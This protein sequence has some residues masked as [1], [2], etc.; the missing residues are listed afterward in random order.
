[1][2]KK[3]SKVLF[4]VSL[5]VLT[6]GAGI[7]SLVSPKSASAEGSN[8]LSI[9]IEGKNYVLEGTTYGT[10]TFYRID[11]AEDLS[12]VSF[13]V[14]V[15]KDKN[16]AGY[17]YELA[18]DIN[19]SSRLWTA[20]GTYDN[21]FTGKFS[22]NG[23]TINGL[24]SAKDSAEAEVFF[25]G[26]SV[27]EP[28]HNTYYHDTT[29]D[30]Y[31]LYQNSGDYIRGYVLQETTPASST[32]VTAKNYYYYG[33]FGRLEKAEVSDVVMGKSCYVYRNNILDTTVDVEAYSGV[34]AAYAKDTTFYN[35][36]DAMA[37]AETVY[38]KEY[39]YFKT[40]DTS[41]LVS[42]KKYY[43]YDEG[44]GT[45]SLVESPELAN[46]GLYYEKVF[47]VN[48]GI[49]NY[50]YSYNIETL[51][52]YNSENMTEANK[53]VSINVETTKT[54]SFRAVDKAYYYDYNA[55]NGTLWLNLKER[56]IVNSVV[57]TTDTETGEVTTINS[58]EVAG[59][60]YYIFG[61]DVEIRLSTTNE[62]PAGDAT[63]VVNQETEEITLDGETY[64][65]A[66][67][68]GILKILAYSEVCSIGYVDQESSFYKGNYYRLN[69][70]DY[71]GIGSIDDGAEHDGVLNMLGAT[72]YY[73]YNV[74][75]ATGINRLVIYSGDY[76]VA[77][78]IGNDAGVGSISVNGVDYLF[79]YDATYKDLDIS[80]ISSYLTN[81]PYT[82][83]ET[84]GAIK[85]E[86]LVV[87]TIFSFSTAINGVET[88][89]Y[90]YEKGTTNYITSFRMIYDEKVGLSSLDYSSNFVST[91]KDLPRS[92]ERAENGQYYIVSD[93]P[94][95]KFVEWTVPRKSDGAE[96]IVYVDKNESDPSKAFI[97][98]IPTTDTEA[99][100]GKTYYRAMGVGV[101]EKVTDGSFD[102]GYHEMLSFE[103][104]IENIIANNYLVN[105][106]WEAKSYTVNVD[107]AGTVTTKTVG[108]GT[109]WDSFVSSLVNAGHDLTGVY[110]YENGLI[111]GSKS[112][113]LV[114]TYSLNYF[115]DNYGNLSTFSYLKTSDSELV[116]GKEYFTCM[117]DGDGF[118]RFTLVETPNVAN[119]TSYY[120][121]A[122]N[123]AIYGN[124]LSNGATGTSV[125]MVEW[126]DANAYLYTTWQRQ[127]VNGKITFTN[128]GDEYIKTSDETLVTGKTYYTYDA[129]SGYS[130]VT[131]P[132]EIDLDLYY[133]KTTKFLINKFA[134]NSGYETNGFK[135]IAMAPSIEGNNTQFFVKLDTEEEN[136][137]FGIK[138][139]AN[140]GY[141][142][143]YIAPESTGVLDI[144]TIDYFMYDAV[145]K[146]LTH[147]YYDS[148]NAVLTSE[149][150]TAKAVFG[151]FVS[152]QTFLEIKDGGEVTHGT[153]YEAFDAT[154]YY[155]DIYYGSMTPNANGLA[156][157]YMADGLAAD[158][159]TVI[160]TAKTIIHK[161]GNEYTYTQN[162][163]TSNAYNLYI[164]F[165]RE[166]FEVN[167]KV[168]QDTGLEGYIETITIVED[169]ETLESITNVREDSS[170]TM[171]VKYDSIYDILVQPADTY[172]I[173]TFEAV[174]MNTPTNETSASGLRI[175]GT[176]SDLKYTGE[177]PT[178]IFE[179]KQSTFDVYSSYNYGI[180]NAE[181]Y[182][183]ALYQN[184]ATDPVLYIQPVNSS[185]TTQETTV[186]K[187]NREDVEITNYGQ[188]AKII[189][190][191]NAYYDV[192]YINVN[193]FSIA[194]DANG[195]FLEKVNATNVN[196]VTYTATS[197]WATVNYKGTNYL[198][199]NDGTQLVADGEGWKL[200]N[201]NLYSTTPETTTVD[202][203]QVIPAGLIGNGDIVELEPILKKQ[204]YT[205]AVDK[206][207]EF[208]DSVFATLRDVNGNEGDGSAFQHYEIYSSV[209]SYSF[210]DSVVLTA[211][212]NAQSIAF[213]SHRFIGWYA[214]IGETINAIMLNGVVD[215]RFNPNN[216]TAQKLGTFDKATNTLTFDKAAPAN[217]EIYAIFAPNSINV[218]TTPLYGSFDSVIKNYDGKAGNKLYSFGNVINAS[219]TMLSL[220]YG[221]TSYA[222][223][224]KRTI[225]YTILPTAGFSLKGWAVVDDYAVWAANGGKTTLD[226]SIDLLDYVTIVYEYENPITNS[227]DIALHYAE[228]LNNET[229]NN[230][231]LFTKLFALEQNYTKGGF[232]LIPVLQ[233]KTVTVT[234]THDEV[235]SKVDNN[236]ED[237]TGLIYYVG[238]DGLDVSAYAERF[239]YQGYTA[240]G[241]SCPDISYTTYSN[242]INFAG[243]PLNY[244][245]TYTVERT[246]APNDYN[247]YLEVG[248]GESI[249]SD[250][251]TVKT[252]ATGKYIA[253]KYAGTFNLPTVGKTGYTFQGWKVKG[254]ETVF[255]DEGKYY[256]AGNTT[257]VPYFTA[258]T[259]KVK[260]LANYG[261]YG[262]DTTEKTVNVVYD[263]AII[264]NAP[265]PTRDGYTFKE[266]ALKND[267]D[268]LTLSS[269]T[270]LSVALSDVDLDEEIVL[271]VY[272]RWTRVADYYTVIPGDA[273]QTYE[274]T[275]SP[276]NFELF[277]DIKAG[278]TSIFD[279][280]WGKVPAT[281]MAV[282]AG[283]SVTLPNGDEIA[284]SLN[285]WNTWDYLEGKTLSLTNVNESGTN[286]IDYLEVYDM[287]EVILSGEYLTT[288]EN[289]LKLIDNKEYTF[290]ITPRTVAKELATSYVGEFDG[291]STLLGETFKN[292]LA[293]GV[294]IDKV[295]VN[296]YAVGH[297]DTQG[298]FT[299]KVD[300]TADGQTYNTIRFY[301]TFADGYTYRPEY[302]NY[303]NVGVEGGKYYFD[304][305][306][307][308]T[309]NKKTIELTP[310]AAKIAYTGSAQTVIFKSSYNINSQEINF[311]ANGTLTAGNYG[312]ANSN[313]TIAVSATTMT[314]SG[315]GF[316]NT[317][318]LGSLVLTSNYNYVLTGS[319]EILGNVKTYGFSGVLVTR[320]NNTTALS[321]PAAIE[322]NIVVNSVEFTAG[323]SNVTID[324]TAETNPTGY[325]IVKMGDITYIYSSNRETLYYQIRNDVNEVAIYS[326]YDVNAVTVGTSVYETN[327]HIFGSYVYDNAAGSGSE[328]D[329]IKTVLQST[330]DKSRYT[331][332][333]TGTEYYVIYTDLQTVQFAGL[334]DAGNE[335]VF[336]Y[337]K[338]GESL[339]YT[340]VGN[341]IKT[342]Y[343]FAGW[344]DA[345]TEP[346]T[347]S[348]DNDEI[349]TT[350]VTQPQNYFVINSTWN[351]QAPTVETSENIT[352]TRE[353]HVD[354]TTQGFEVS[355]SEIVG[356]I[357]NYN[358]NLTYNATIYAPDNSE[359]VSASIQSGDASF[360][361][362]VMLSTTDAGVY[363]LKISVTDADGKTSETTVN[364][365]LVVNRIAVELSTTETYTTKTGYFADATK[366]ALGDDYKFEF[367]YSHGKS[368]ED[369]IYVTLN[370]NGMVDKFSLNS[371][372][373]MD[374][375]EE[376]QGEL[377]FSYTIKKTIDTDGSAIDRAVSTIGEVGTY[378]VTINIETTYYSAEKQLYFDVVI[379]PAELTFTDASL[380]SLLGTTA[381]ETAFEKTYGDD[382]SVLTQTFYVGANNIVYATAEA[383]GVGN[384]AIEVIF[385]GEGDKMAFDSTTSR[386][387][388]VGNYA[389]TK[390]RTTNGNFTISVSSTTG[391]VPY[392][393]VVSNNNDELMFTVDNTTAPSFTYGDT[394]ITQVKLAWNTTAGKWELQGFDENDVKK[395]TWNLSNIVAGATSYISNNTTFTNDKY[396]FGINTE[397]YPDGL[398]LAGVYA[399]DALS[400]SSLEGALLTKVSFTTGNILTIAQKTLTITSMAREELIIK[401][402]TFNSDANTE[403]TFSVEGL[404]YGDTVTLS[405]TIAG[406]NGW[407][408]GTQTVTDLT[409]GG[410][411]ATNYKLANTTYAS[412]TIGK[413][414]ADVVV[415]IAN[416]SYG[417][418]DINEIKTLTSIKTGT[419]SLIDLASVNIEGVE[420]LDTDEV[421][422]TE[423]STGGYVKA[424]T[425]KVRL[426]L[427]SS[428]FTKAAGEFVV[429]FVVEKAT[430]TVAPSETIEK[431][432]DGNDNVLQSF[433]F[434]SKSGDVVV[435]TGKYA[436]VAEANGI[437]I[438]LTKTGA[439]AVNYE[440]APETAITGNILP[441]DGIGLT[442]DNSK[443]T[444][445]EDGQKPYYVDA[446]KPTADA[447]GNFQITAA[448]S[449]DTTGADIVAAL[450]NPVRTG[451]RFDGFFTDEDL[452]VALSAD[453][454][455][456]LINAHISGEN[457][458]SNF[459]VYAKWTIVA[460][461]IA[462]TAEGN[463]DLE[464]EKTTY[465]YYDDVAFTVTA[466]RGYTLT[467]VAAN[468]TGKTT[469]VDLANSGDTYS[470]KM[471]AYG[472]T[473]TRTTSPNK[474]DIAY[475][476]DGGSFEAPQ[477]QEFTFGIGATIV[478]PIKK[479]HKFVGW[480]VN[481]TGSAVQTTG[482][483]VIGATTYAD[484]ISLTAKWEA[485]T[486]RIY[487][488]VDETVET[489]NTTGL[490]LDN[491]SSNAETFK[492]YY[493]EIV[494]GTQISLPESSKPGYGF[495][496]WVYG[497][498]DTVLAAGSNYEID[499]NVIVKAVYEAGTFETT[500]TA[501]HATITVYREIKSQENIVSPTGNKYSMTGGVK[502]IINVKADT[503]YKVGYA[504]YEADS[505]ID[506]EYYA[507]ENKEINFVAEALSHTIAINVNQQHKSLIEFVVT[508]DGQVVAPQSVEAGYKFEAQTD[509]VVT[510]KVTENA[511]Y[512]L[513]EPVVS[514]LE[515]TPNADGDVFT[516][517]GYTT[518]ASITFSLTAL[519]YDITINKDADGKISQ[520]DF[521]EGA[522]STAQH[523]TYWTAN[524]TTDA[525]TLQF[526]PTVD[527]GYVFRGVAYN[528]T[529]VNINDR[530]ENIGGTTLTIAID[531]SGKVSITGYTGAATVDLL[532]AEDSYT[533]KLSIIALDGEKK[534]TSV[535]SEIKVNSEAYDASNN[536]HLYNESITI[537]ANVTTS[538]YKFVGWFTKVTDETDGTVSYDNINLMY[539]QDTNTFT[540][541]NSNIEYIAVFE[542]TYLDINFSVLTNDDVANNKGGKVEDIA[543]ET[544][545]TDRPLYKTN[546]TYKAVASKGYKFV[547][548]YI[549]D[550]EDNEVDATTLA[551][552]TITTTE[553]DADD[554]I[555]ESTLAFE[556][557]DS[558]KVYAKF[559]AK[560]LE[561][562]VSKGLLV[563]GTLTYPDSI[564]YGQVEWGTYTVDGGFV[565]DP[566][567]SSDTI[568]T[569]TDGVVY[570]K[571][572]A[573]DG[574]LIDGIV[575]T[576]KGSFAIT[577]IA[578]Q[579]GYKIYELAGMNADDESHSFVARFYSTE[580]ILTINYMTASGRV[581]EGGH[582]VVTAGEG[583]S[584]SA[585]RSSKVT[586]TAITGSTIEI[587]AFTRLGYHF[588]KDPDT[589][590]INYSYLDAS[591]FRGTLE[592]P[593]TI[594]V[595][596]QD[597]S[598]GY[599]EAVSFTISGFVG[600]NINLSLIVNVDRY[601]VELYAVDEDL[602]VITSKPVATIENVSG[603][604]MITPDYNAQDKIS[605][606]IKIPGYSL[607]GFYTY[608]N[609]S[610]I[611]YINARGEGVVTLNDNGY[612]WNGSS[613]QK[614]P[615]YR[616][617]INGNGTFSLFA[618]YTIDKTAIS[619]SASPFDL[620]EIAPTVSTKVVI[621]NLNNANSWTVET[622]E[623]YA[624]VLYGATVNATAPKFA[625]H[626]FAF[627]QIE[628][629]D[630]NGTTSIRYNTSETIVDL[631]DAKSGKGHAYSSM[632]L[633]AVYYVHAEVSATSG[634]SATITGYTYNVASNGQTA[635]RIEKIV[636][637]Q[638]DFSSL[639]PIVYK[640]TP[641]Y[642]YTFE[643]WA[644]EEGQIVYTSEEVTINPEDA[645]P[646]FLQAVFTGD[647]KTLAITSDSS[648]IGS[649]E[650]VYRLDEE[651]MEVEI[652]DLSNI[653]VR[654]GDV[655]YIDVKVQSVSYEA[656]WSGGNVDADIYST[657][658]ARRY[659]YTVAA[660]DEVE[661]NI[662]RLN[663]SYESRRFDITVKYDLNDKVSTDEL[664]LA[665]SIVYKKVER[666]SGYTINTIYG[667]AVGVNINVKKNYKVASIVIDGIE[668][669]DIKKYAN[670]GT[671]TIQTTD[672]I[673]EVS[674]SVVVEIT[675]ERV[676]W[677]D[678][679]DTT[680]TLSGKGTDEN[681]YKIASEEDLA[682]LAYMV[683]VKKDSKF[684]SASYE[685]TKDIDLTG[686]YWSPIGTADCPFKGSFD[687]NVYSVTG[688]TVVFGYRGQTRF[689]GV[690]GTVSNA[691]I[692]KTESNVGLIVGII[693]GTLAVIG[694]GVGVFLGIRAKKKK[695]HEKL[696]NS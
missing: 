25:N 156:E 566:N 435:I 195:V 283:P 460:Y 356:A 580:T 608:A 151:Y 498:E 12:L 165:V 125:F 152:S 359:F 329:V 131:S 21:P 73:D 557:V 224:A 23:Y 77:T 660:E 574:Y 659:I 376:H 164:D 349:I 89:A 311:I 238:G 135:G 289:F 495:K 251:D 88:P 95:Y 44:T 490:T 122:Q 689:D 100:A 20:I 642:G 208:K 41:S 474:Y 186:P 115:Y 111:D 676:V 90:F 410:Q 502:Y 572:T 527:I 144:T 658:T 327:Y 294:N 160:L 453:T 673:Y 121:K 10:E 51:T 496:N 182:S 367:N 312:A 203:N 598:L 174:D 541:P 418:S 626:K 479:G 443:N 620:T 447:S 481:G 429:A 40:L 423:R 651:G 42:G 380:K 575:N 526:K 132:Q 545:L 455:V 110:Y 75:A 421:A 678:V 596:P 493:K 19:L 593:S 535:V 84:E 175:T 147:V 366:V 74:D 321:A 509:A 364:W 427:S 619:I 114:H 506:V 515:V 437:A 661:D 278:I 333:T 406:E 589:K 558:I 452:I 680:Y 301:F 653:S 531:E 567:G 183:D 549:L 560:A 342:G 290:T 302:G 390:G 91:A 118:A 253:V 361:H 637:S 60:T 685:L 257:L 32:D 610:G 280:E 471:P 363:T 522:N 385:A 124:K 281:G 603:G 571:V 336:D 640:A 141:K 583:I 524:V 584:I 373:W 523:E 350:S 463:S 310:Y 407:K 384:V 146:T 458:N 212:D 507:I 645:T 562:S 476:L 400:V 568:A 116:E 72:Y 525:G 240:T 341:K 671:L 193:I 489:L 79:H 629:V 45:Y 403:D 668:V 252:D 92:Y 328:L 43:T 383:A 142:V 326:L 588:D 26:A 605:K 440:I 126:N 656:V 609:G 202:P 602:N 277:K 305:T 581:V 530:K 513:N 221:E 316:E 446:G 510:I 269:T 101:Y 478:D 143:N 232:T 639:D 249:K 303:A 542:I 444:F 601:S 123:V 413:S 511:G 210:G 462:I 180:D 644:N 432:Y 50:Y 457:G 520:V 300:A 139:T 137:L 225:S 419:Q 401:D 505:Y 148:T 317:G 226:A 262:D 521:Y 630:V 517:S 504:G 512:T 486:Y 425:Y 117:I 24:N 7:I 16:W 245:A 68:N 374:L 430:L 686:K 38:A 552:Y 315:E 236:G 388:G 155:V 450:G 267:G 206:K 372:E 434:N 14:S 215:E 636:S 52:I 266:W 597:T 652:S 621:S 150:V 13:M 127:P 153:G 360:G 623:F 627:W 58:I 420:L 204:V 646:M 314:I 411:F 337:I 272:A 258:N 338:I 675:F 681:P 461:D 102:T 674:Q 99:V 650:R 285:D 414:T 556:V 168:T 394:I 590:S 69:S 65:C 358:E 39:G 389:I 638:Y 643:G 107:I 679:V 154:K 216:T 582:A 237:V 412:L 508:V 576:G 28:V 691:N 409:L 235:D 36:Y 492:K 27:L 31:Y 683:N 70:I 528:G 308:I 470:F 677:T 298:N 128:T 343:D 393:K 248:A 170:V 286:I 529:V 220:T 161:N 275:G 494:F 371:D 456:S 120:E 219:S 449:A 482:Q 196:V 438:N 570:V 108:Y 211:K 559:E 297:T 282:Y 191:D 2:I 105:A 599:T 445:V 611:K 256:T 662:I 93:T 672:F 17:N 487:F 37:D 334:G 604:G 307:S 375:D 109:K 320:E 404:V 322:G 655:I 468:E 442:V 96:T 228:L 185:V 695:E 158:G 4:S 113:D 648:S 398:K 448:F 565:K 119:I 325:V 145:A 130:V 194:S 134:V 579:D 391:E 86:E 59:V 30:L 690:F 633:T 263:T 330:A 227:S 439:D 76:P 365:T 370:G 436:T 518:N 669:E 332:L 190:A 313:T 614:S 250:G 22:G 106:K 29:N 594:L 284:F 207:G 64:P 592:F 628:R 268:I 214:K 259:Y 670:G 169:G 162:K 585:N 553:R 441:R 3:L 577:V 309:V 417:F 179:L 149:D 433:T 35:I 532:V 287:A 345:T 271:A 276:I 451:Y 184:G 682:F 663:A 103:E 467:S 694:I 466:K 61:N 140:T 85:T 55:E 354:Y 231:D 480:I 177:G 292:N 71:I 47:R 80:T 11:T 613:Y 687:F 129:T 171:K 607:Q 138:F 368:Y 595:S 667:S 543:G 230:M 422:V 197:Y 15:V 213:K 351:I 18:N 415:T 98:L 564:T 632:K 260:F 46:V 97:S 217:V 377:K 49:Y 534:P 497:T 78:G 318:S 234:L 319:I 693:G 696:A 274:Y 428:D 242:T 1:M 631:L 335:T 684:A 399:T 654:V 205:V 247:I 362:P 8:D 381:K 688:I 586:V 538:G 323:A 94:G 172:S 537:S 536:A 255:T 83:A 551:G 241:W 33:L 464:I 181:K 544:V 355:L 324:P 187:G 200:E 229:G 657:D 133:E 405:G 533:L 484:D 514:G 500:L 379:N 554:N 82:I 54:G 616:E 223:S 261:K 104:T 192:E 485:N 198:V 167:L 239:G 66:Y 136:G 469:V 57:S 666:K 6:C 348:G 454:I 617:D 62:D 265:A 357:T 465:N 112:G 353:A 173:K 647:A 81:I 347:V 304:Q 395:V 397:K 295:V 488:N 291:T 563:N 641:M 299:A 369:Y 618:V 516:I 340:P 386:E 569:E 426:T 622:D 424:G 473:I 519:S 615:Y 346:Y 475:N 483:F 246:F 176:F 296:N 561:I 665:G 9:T 233:Q 635:N 387:L 472:V 649:I 157:I 166:E 293:N 624:E 56:Y 218:T 53:V 279:M 634:G 339:S 48:A 600:G 201:A 416:G 692:F 431:Q 5:A 501:E 625:G 352:I 606:M 587:L 199:V 612:Y 273:T 331:G 408:A 244:N 178:L 288:N 664:K 382:N 163:F 222:D 491:D 578:T 270:T 396:V 550:E 209:N 306:T 459:V 540:M 159:T 344:A 503:G 477:A 555:I 539:A 264:T 67:E 254:T 591:E 243:K 392:L 546:V 63:I 378:R 188:G 547:G 573:L 402:T 548:W 499:E 189:I 34:L 87:G